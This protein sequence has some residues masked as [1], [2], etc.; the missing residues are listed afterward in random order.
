[1]AGKT[2]KSDIEDFLEYNP[3]TGEFF[4]KKFKGARAPV[5]KVMNAPCKVWGYIFIR[6]N[7]RLYRAHHLA[8]LLMTGEFPSQEID[9]VNGDR[10]DNRWCNLR[11]AG[12]SKNM[13]NI[14][15]PR[16]DINTS[17]YRGVHTYRDRFRAVITI[18]KKLVYLGTFNSALEAS[19]R[20]TEFKQLYLDMCYDGTQKETLIDVD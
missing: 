4:W 8:W 13:L 7:K 2:T 10:A 18:N 3:I 15:T 16:P 17:G 1:M 5:G 6:F 14:H 11:E 19:N 9:H 20:Y 12:K